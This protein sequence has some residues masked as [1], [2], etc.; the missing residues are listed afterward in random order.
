MNNE[1]WEFEDGTKI[2]CDSNSTTRNLD[3][4]YAPLTGRSNVPSPTDVC[5]P[6][7]KPFGID[8]YMYFSGTYLSG[9][10]NIK[11]KGE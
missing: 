2:T 5:D 4:L 11:N 6:F 3:Y 7:R 8:V 10:H 9:L 1:Y